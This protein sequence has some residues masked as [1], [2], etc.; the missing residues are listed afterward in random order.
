MFNDN[1]KAKQHEVFNRSIYFAINKC[2]FIPNCAYEKDYLIER[3]PNGGIVRIYITDNGRYMRSVYFKT[4][5]CIVGCCGFLFNSKTAEIIWAE[6]NPAD[7]NKSIYK[8]LKAVTTLLTKKR[9][10]SQF[11]SDD[12]L[13]AAKLAG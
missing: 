5:K 13:K 1:S 7:R 12:L 4:T 11:Q 6:T 8:Q 10:F 9:F 2:T 3:L